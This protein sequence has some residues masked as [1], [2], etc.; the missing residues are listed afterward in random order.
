MSNQRPAP[1]L[2]FDDGSRVISESVIEERPR[3]PRDE[4]IGVREYYEIDR[5]VREINQLRKVERI[6]LQFPD[7]LLDDAP[8]VCWEFEKS[9][10]GA[11][12]FVL[13]EASCCPDQVA[14]AHL[15]ADAL[16]HYG[17]ACLTPCA[18][19]PVL[20]S[21]G[22]TLIDI[23]TCIEQVLAEA[24]A[25]TTKRLLLLYELAY[26][27]SMEELQTRLSEQ[28]DM[29]VIAGEIP[30]TGC[31]GP[32]AETEAPSTDSE[33]AVVPENFVVGGLELPSGMDWS[34]Y[35]ML[36][37]GDSSTRQYLNLVLRFLSGS[38]PGAIVTDYWTWNP[39]TKSLTTTPSPSF[40]RRLNRRFYLVQKARE[41]RVIGIVVGTL[42]DARL[43]SVVASLRALID[44][45]GRASYTFCVG[46]L[47]PAKLA[48][49][50]E[51]DCFCLVACPEH[52]LLDDDREYHIP[53]LTPYELAIAVGAEEWGQRQYSLDSRDYLQVAVAPLVIEDDS[54]A[55]A[56]YF[57]LVTGQYESR[58]QKQETDLTILPGQG[59]VT[60]YHSVA[61][62]FLKQREY[63]GLQV[64]AG[65][66]KVQAAVPGQQ[67]I[68]SDYGDR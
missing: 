39:L 23:D 3:R 62:D 5:L 42:T 59:K 46:K 2:V 14:A 56:P 9:I 47:N 15:S 11:L 55:D 31:C 30:S 41:A 43:Q 48:N 33:T 45:S 22:L 4:S 1:Q 65:A 7:A 25:S 38:D 35:T 52:S 13:G 68:A 61:A 12:V 66:T 29:L 44:D 49:F 17:H 36:Y 50:A 54:D 20:Y 10:D 63:Q 60:A 24:K 8:E 40:R 27:S 37:V 67:G 26:H 58:P 21:F 34:S 28:G 53:V 64:E 57:S 16:V 51:I 18:A 19:L 32:A 6:A